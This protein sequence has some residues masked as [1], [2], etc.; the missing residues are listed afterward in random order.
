MCNDLNYY[1]CK[2]GKPNNLFNEYLAASFCKI[3]GIPVPDFSFVKVEDGHIPEGYP[4]ADFSYPCFG[5]FYLEYALDANEFLNTWKG[6]NNEIEKI[7]NKADLLKIGLFDLWL[8]NEDRNHNNHNL[9]INPTVEGY[10]I[11]AID[12]VT[13]F[14]TNSLNYK[15]EQ[16]TENESIIDTVFCNMLFKRGVKLNEMLTELEE[17]FYLCVKE[18][19]EK[20]TKILK[21]VPNE[22][23][24]DVVE[25]EKR[26]RESLFDEVW[27]RQTMSYFRTVLESSLDKN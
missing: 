2:Y 21:E 3:W 26:I 16:L 24:I 17:N 9:L 4:K 14:N 11:V 27:S 7:F 1:A 23:N 18:C 25:R 15:L 22:W 6:K 12:H 10:Q 13:I 20:F 5:S 8:S 19:S